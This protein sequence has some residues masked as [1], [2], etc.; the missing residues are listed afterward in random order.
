M[1]VWEGKFVCCFTQ[2]TFS[3]RVVSAKGVSN[4]QCSE[5]IFRGRNHW[6]RWPKNIWAC[7]GKIPFFCGEIKQTQ[8]QKSHD[9]SWK[10]STLQNQKAPRKQIW[11]FLPVWS[12]HRVAASLWSTNLGPDFPGDV[13]NLLLQIMGFFNMPTLQHLF[14]RNR[15]WNYPKPGYLQLPVAQLLVT[16]QLLLW[17]PMISV[18]G[19]RRGSCQAGSAV[20]SGCSVLCVPTC[21]KQG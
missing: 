17:E 5:A 8:Q 9:S 15:A 3:G 20:H 14:G 7:F 6:N 21:R 10:E 18:F 13:G 4:S 1:W 12:C 11:Y 16:V 19:L 2:G